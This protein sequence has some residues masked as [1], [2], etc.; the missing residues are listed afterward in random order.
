VLPSP[1]DHSHDVGVLVDSS[2][3]RTPNGAVPEVA[4]DTKAATGVEA[5]DAG[6]ISIMLAK[7]IKRPAARE[8]DFMGSPPGSAAGCVHERTGVAWVT[9]FTVVQ[10]PLEVFI[11][12]T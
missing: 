3:K 2:I 4:F 6:R 8:D 12:R 10:S 9:P 1:K 11:L 5:A 7:R